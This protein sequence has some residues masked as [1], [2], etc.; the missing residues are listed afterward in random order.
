MAKETKHL[1]SMPSSFVS[2]PIVPVPGTFD[3]AGM[4]RGEP[5]LPGKFRWRGK[6]FTVALELERWREHGDCRNGSDERYVRKHG[7]RVRTEDGSIMRLYFQRT[8]GRGRL[9]PKTRWWLHS[10]ES[11]APAAPHPK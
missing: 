10:I 6:E 11:C 1:K 5:G 2:E 4:S 9:S 3:A 8:V 7:Y